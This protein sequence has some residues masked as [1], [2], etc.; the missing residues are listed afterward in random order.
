MLRRAIDHDVDEHGCRAIRVAV[1]SRKIIHL[2]G[3]ANSWSYT[4]IGQ[5]GWKSYGHL[6]R[7]RCRVEPIVS[8][9]V[10]K[11]V[12][13]TREIGND[14]VIDNTPRV[15]AARL[16]VPRKML[17][18]AIDHDVDECGGS[19]IRV[20]ISSRKVIRLRGLPTI[21]FTPKLDNRGGVFV[22]FT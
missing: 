14:R 1:S 7:R 6:I 15:I 20:A 16:N 13:S 17:R 5:L 18:R 3:D 22:T 21:G 2:G 12:I 10:K 19:A 11:R 9:F 8:R 4:G